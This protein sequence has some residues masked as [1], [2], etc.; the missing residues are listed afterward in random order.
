M[1]TGSGVEVGAMARMGIGFSHVAIIVE[2]VASKLGRVRF[3][4]LVD[5]TTST[6]TQEKTINSVY[7]IKTQ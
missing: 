7:G 3:T 2:T 6:W 4:L 5:K 1:D